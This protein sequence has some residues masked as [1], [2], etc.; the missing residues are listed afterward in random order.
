[1]NYQSISFYCDGNR[2]LHGSI[3]FTRHPG[4]LCSFGAAELNERAG[5]QS[6][7]MRSHMNTA[8]VQSFEGML[9]FVILSDG[10]GIL[11]IFICGILE[12]RY[13]VYERGVVG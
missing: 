10:I 3:A 7:N 1:M 9:C 8:A 12:R 4:I 13:E 11:D 2:G 5:S 6:E